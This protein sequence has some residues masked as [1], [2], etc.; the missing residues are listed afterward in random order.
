MDRNP[1][2]MKMEQFT[3]FSDKDRWVLDDLAFKRQRRYGAREDIIREGEHSADVHLVLSGWACRYKML[4]D[5]GRQ[6]I[7]FLVPGDLCDPEIFILKEMDHSIGTLAPS[8]I[9]AIPGETMRDLVLKHPRIAVALWWGTLTDEGVLRA[10]IIDIGRRDAYQ[11]IAHLLHELLIRLR[12]VGVMTD[13]SFE[14]PI[15]QVDIADATG[16]TH[17]YVNRV[18]Q[19][20]RDEG[21]IA[22]QRKRVTITDP[23]G[24]KEAGQF[25][26]NY[27]HLDRVHDERGGLAG[28]A[29]DLV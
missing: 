16:L 6:I 29:G 12:I 7:A 8:T 14:L 5:G 26:P 3:L 2:I 17:V 10:R 28:R 15:T 13:N 22:W 20:L 27:L 18:M 1:W 23:E 24:L 25:N 11:R 21:L 19:R 9:A 4:A